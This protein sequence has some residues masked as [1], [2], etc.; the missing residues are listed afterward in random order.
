[1]RRLKNA[2][3]ARRQQFEYW[4]RLRSKAAKETAKALQSSPVNERGQS[5]K[6]ALRHDNQEAMSIPPRPQSEVSRSL[7]SSVAVLSRDFEFKD[8]RSTITGTSR[9]LTVHG[10]SGQ[11]I[12]WPHAPLNIPPDKPF[13]CPYC[14]FFCPSKHLKDSAWR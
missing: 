12:T 5:Q 11:A 3:H 9:G 6:E 1:V 4:K 10:P 13:E 8:D 2:N 14:F 7:L